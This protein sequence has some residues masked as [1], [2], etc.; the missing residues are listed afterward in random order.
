MTESDDDVTLEDVFPTAEQ[1]IPD[2]H[3]HGKMPK[4]LNDDALAERTE[5]ERVAAGLE[6]YDP[7]TVPDADA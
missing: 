4:H 7:N 1:A 5:Q 3:A 2:R 6:D